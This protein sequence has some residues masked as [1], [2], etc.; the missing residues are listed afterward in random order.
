MIF[1]FLLLTRASVD[2]SFNFKTDGVTLLKERLYLYLLFNYQTFLRDTYIYSCS[3]ADPGF[4]KGG[5]LFTN[6]FVYYIVKAPVCCL[7]G[8]GG[9]RVLGSFLKV[10]RNKYRK[11]QIQCVFCSLTCAKIFSP[12]QNG[13]EQLCLLVKLLRCEKTV[14]KLAKKYVNGEENHSSKAKITLES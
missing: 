10:Y 9:F 6:I 1:G 4:F 14:R 12:W 2:N 7:W 3:G 8:G 5:W 11:E 13:L